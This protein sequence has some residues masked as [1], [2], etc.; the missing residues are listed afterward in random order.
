M[1]SK[2]GIQFKRSY[3]PATQP[4]ASQLNEGE[5]AINLTDKKLY[6]LDANNEVIN[7]GFDFDTYIADQF[8]GSTG[9]PLSGLVTFDTSA[10]NGNVDKDIAEGSSYNLVHK[11]YVDDSV[12]KLNS[13]VETNLTSYLKLDGSEVMTGQL[14]LSSRAPTDPQHATSKQYVDSTFIPING[15]L[16]TPIQTR[17]NVSNT[18]PQSDNELVCKGYTDSQYLNINTGGAVANLKVNKV[19]VDSSDVVRNLELKK[20]ASDIPTKIVFGQKETI[21]KK[22]SS[23]LNNIFA[24]AGHIISGISFVVDDTDPTKG[25]IITDVTITHQSINISA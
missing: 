1:S 21:S 9:G 13:D 2:Y 25:K 22:L 24:P 23:G 12:S 14:K 18:Q 19:P 10:Y 5:L 11:K 4:E 7:I 16:R 15:D 17:L 6:T 20:L 3:A 8:L